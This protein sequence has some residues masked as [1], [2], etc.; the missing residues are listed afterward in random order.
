MNSIPSLIGYFGSASHAVV[1]E[2]SLE[3][4]MD[5][6]TLIEPFPIQFSFNTPGWYFTGIVLFV[7]V[8]L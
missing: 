3:L 7:F 6:A 5:S 8:I 1:E 2:N 4:I